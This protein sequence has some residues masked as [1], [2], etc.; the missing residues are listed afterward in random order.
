MYLKLVFFVVVA[1]LIGAS[2]ASDSDEC[3]PL[4]CDTCATTS[5]C[6]WVNCTTSPEGFTLMFSPGMCRETH[7]QVSS[8]CEGDEQE[9]KRGDVWQEACN[10]LT[11]GNGRK[12]RITDHICFS[13]CYWLSQHDS[14]VTKRDLQQRYLL[15]SKPNNLCTYDCFPYYYSPL[16]PCCP[17]PLLAPALI[18]PQ[19]ILPPLGPTSSSNSSTSIPSTSSNQHNHHNRQFSPLPLTRTQ[20]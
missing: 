14:S 13:V 10:I 15:S 2:A 19:E 16:Y 6:H 3:A 18:P 11:L 8:D 12:E 4:S 9:R 17:Q 7:T 1:A 20:P 5:D